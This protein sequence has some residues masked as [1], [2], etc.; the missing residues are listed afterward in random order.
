MKGSVIVVAILLLPKLFLIS[1][2]LYLCCN[3]YDNVLVFLIHI[4][5]FLLLI[6]YIHTTQKPDILI[7]VGR[8][9]MSTIGLR[10]F[11]KLKD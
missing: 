11:E 4:S 3:S 1:F 7:E 10:R 6:F 9:L 8:Q 2:H 5:S